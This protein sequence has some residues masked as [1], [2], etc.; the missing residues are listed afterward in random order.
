MQLLNTNNLKQI[1]LLS[2]IVV[3]GLSILN[4]FSVFVPSVLAAA[5]LYI[6]IRH[7][8]IVLVGYWIFGVESFVFWGVL[9]GVFSI[10]PIVGCALVWV[11]IC[12]YMV[13]EGDTA[14]AIWLAVYSFVVTGGVDNVLRF[15]ILDKIGDVHP[16]ITTIGIIIGVPM[17]GFMGFIFGPLLVSYL[18]LLVKIYR[19]EFTDHKPRSDNPVRRGK[20][21]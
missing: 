16:I 21:T 11:P 6:L 5:T 19:V 20:T 14:N 4:R 17:F 8:Y 13:M 18:L 7:W 3:L 1:A 15:T 2:L 12:I 10:V 9:T